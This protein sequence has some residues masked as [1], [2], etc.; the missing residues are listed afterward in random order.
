MASSVL[1]HGDLWHGNMVATRAGGPA[2]IDP[3]VCWMW[4]EADLSMAY[5]TGGVPPR[6]FDAYQELSPL[7]A[8]W[9]ER[10]RLLHLRELLSVVAHVGATRADLSEIRKIVRRYAWSRACYESRLVRL[11]DMP[12]LWP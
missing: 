4:A 7:A 9:Q 8:G 2:F 3:A 10:M 6:F 5:S 11:S 12:T 1:T